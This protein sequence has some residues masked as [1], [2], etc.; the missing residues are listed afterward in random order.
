MT[1]I[2]ASKSPKGPS[3]LDKDPDEAKELFNAKRQVLLKWS[4]PGV[5]EWIY[6]TAG[7]HL[8]KQSII[9]KD[10]NSSQSS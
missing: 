4:F 1:M 8:M 3:L 6:M 5:L 10:V 9:S 2:W 7:G